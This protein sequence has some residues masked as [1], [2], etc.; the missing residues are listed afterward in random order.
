ML[1]RWSLAALVFAGCPKVPVG[2]EPPFEARFLEC[3]H[4]SLGV[5]LSR[6]GTDT[7]EGYARDN[8]EDSR[9]GSCGWDGAA[10]VCRGTWSFTGT[11]S[12][13]RIERRGEGLV[14]QIGRPA[15]GTNEYPCF[16]TD[17]GLGACVLNPQTPTCPAL[18]SP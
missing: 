13:L 2:A 18:P 9:Y 5:S 4:H 17:Q 12:D 15:G 11:S 14:V 3:P 6:S 16:A 1:L 7:Y 10:L 8:Y